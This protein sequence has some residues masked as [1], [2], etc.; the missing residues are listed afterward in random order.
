MA[1]NNWLNRTTKQLILN[2]DA[3]SMS[4][5]FV[6]DFSA[7]A[8]NT[9]WIYDP[10]LS[11]ADGWPSKY[12]IV[13]AYPSD[14]VTLMTLAQRDMV[15]AAALEAIR[16]ASTDQLDNLEDVLRAFVLVVI[17][18]FNLLRQQFNAST[19]EVSQLTTTT[20]TDRTVEQLRSAIRGRLGS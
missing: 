8:S 19:A 7:Y 17:D 11:A 1:D 3:A 2:T 9:G 16:D 18:E 12:W 14:A 15:D 20:F 13:A 10:D 6:G 4:E 5:R